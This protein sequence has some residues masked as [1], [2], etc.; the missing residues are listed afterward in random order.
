MNTLFSI[1][2]V[3]FE[4]V[5]VE[6][7]KATLGHY[8]DFG[9]RYVALYDFLI[10]ETVVT[11]ALWTAVLGTNPSRF[12]GERNPV[13]SV[14]F[15]EIETF[16]QKLDALTGHQFRLPSENEWEYAARGGK[17]SHGY[18]Y[19]GSDNINEVAWYWQ[20]SGRKAI[21]GTDDDWNADMIFRKGCKTHPVAQK[22][23]NEL[24][25]YDMSGNVWEWC[26]DSYQPSSPEDTPQGI[27]HGDYCVTRGGSWTSSGECCRVFRN[28]FQNTGEGGRSSSNGFRL[29]LSL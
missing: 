17:L 2:G 1:N 25:I 27:G 8:P 22:K 5:R 18:L 13:E 16:L 23:P 14:T 6:G 26:G 12:K 21:R 28:G 10:G 20:N 4:M 11:Q 7:G 29:A 9:E 24:G 19:S 3:D 15:G